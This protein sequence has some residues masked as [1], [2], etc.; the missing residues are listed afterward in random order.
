MPGA[1][2][3]AQQITVA[4]RALSASPTHKISVL[5]TQENIPLQKCHV[6]LLSSLKN[7]GHLATGLCSLILRDAGT[8]ILLPS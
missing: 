7:L 5:A 2:C 3:A 6:L 4:L 8:A 1:V